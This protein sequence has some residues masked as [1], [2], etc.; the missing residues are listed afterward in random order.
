MQ[1]EKIEALEVEGQTSEVLLP[2]LEKLFETYTIEKILYVN[3]PGS[4]MAIKLTYIM[5]R[6]IEMLRGIPFAGVS[7]F[8][9]NNAEPIKAMGLLYFTK[10]KETIMTK[11]FDEIRKQKFW[12]PDDLRA[13]PLE[14][15][16]RPDYILPAV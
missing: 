5:L 14:R 11:K 15:E 2:L 6:S 1:D 7:G 8:A 16:N 13:L 3:G 12:L 10:E 4:Y 9:L